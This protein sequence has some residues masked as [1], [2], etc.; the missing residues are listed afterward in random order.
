[1]VGAPQ[2]AMLAA[3]ADGEVGVSSA[4]KRRLA[5]ERRKE[6]LAKAC[7]AEVPFASHAQQRAL[8]LT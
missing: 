5:V 7:A 2:P 1:M 3:R 6:M 8:E 4:E